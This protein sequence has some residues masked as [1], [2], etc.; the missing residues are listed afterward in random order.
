MMGEERQRAAPT[1]K[2]RLSLRVDRAEIERLLAMMGEKR[3]RA[4]PTHKGRRQPCKSNRSV[5]QLQENGS[6]SAAM[7]D[8]HFQLPPP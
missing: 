1:H 6:R 7:L 3:Q 8:S 4:A 2:S 5:D